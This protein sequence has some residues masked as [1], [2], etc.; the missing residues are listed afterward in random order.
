[1][2]STVTPSES[3]MFLH[4]WGNLTIKNSVKTPVITAKGYDNVSCSD[5][6]TAAINGDVSHA[7]VYGGALW[8]Q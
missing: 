8:F 7:Y 2:M 6:T 1:M 3:E 5:G 4:V